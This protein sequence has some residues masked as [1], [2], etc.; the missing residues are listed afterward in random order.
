M[1]RRADEHTS[2]LRADEE[3]CRRAKIHV[4]GMERKY[5]QSNNKNSDPISSLVSYHF[6]SVLSYSTSPTA[7]E[8]SSIDVRAPLSSPPH[9][10]F[11]RQSHTTIVYIIISKMSPRALHSAQLAATMSCNYTCV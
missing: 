1:S 8:Y 11:E 6:E 7:F 4:V 2:C 9:W 3:T 5:A 10:M